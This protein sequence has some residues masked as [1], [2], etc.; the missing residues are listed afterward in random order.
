[1]PILMMIFKHLESG[2]SLQ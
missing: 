1:M 2:W